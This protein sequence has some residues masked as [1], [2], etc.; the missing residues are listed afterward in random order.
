M[1]ARWW[2]A[3]VD[4]G[5]I[6]CGVVVLALAGLVARSEM[7]RLEVSVFEAVNN[8]PQSLYR[9]VWPLMQYGTIVTIPVLAL[10]AFAFR[11]VRLGL[12]MM[13]AGVSVYLLALVVKELVNRGRPGALIGGVDARETFGAESLGFPSG[14]A[15]VAAALTVV[16]AAHLSRRWAIA[17]VLLALAVVF[18][19]IYVGAHLPLDLVGGAALGAVAG[20]VANLLI[21]PSP[22]SPP[23]ERDQEVVRND[24]V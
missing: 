14:H 1:R 10:I 2:H 11:R 21:P 20:G 9:L 5:T 13:L 7:T 22:P 16:V 15:A 6:A 8:L 23:R 12:A 19:R 18:G 17:A 3:R 24:P 4:L